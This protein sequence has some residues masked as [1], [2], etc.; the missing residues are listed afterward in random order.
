M[1]VRDIL[2]STITLPIG[3][4]ISD[5]EPWT[6]VL[7]FTRASDSSFTVTD[8]STNQAIFIPGRAI[9]YRATAGTYVYGIV[10]NYAAGTVTLDGAPLT[11]SYDDEMQYA[12]GEKVITLR[13]YYPSNLTTGDDQGSPALKWQEGT[14][15]LVRV[16][17]QLETAPT[18]AND[19]RFAVGVGA[20]ANDVLNSPVYIELGGTSE[21]DS[22]ININITNYSIAFGEQVYL[23]IDQI[24]STIPGAGLG[25]TYTFIK[26]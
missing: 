14:A 15:Y 5:F 6:D 19:V 20:A 25:V 10:V 1:L 16:T 11:T 24:G 12:E 4:G 3:G 2:M 7:S 26:E 17:G 13:D 21:V 8:N 23:N 22:G 18:G 9:R